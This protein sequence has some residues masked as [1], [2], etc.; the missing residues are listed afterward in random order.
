MSEKEFEKL[1]T[2]IIDELLSRGQKKD[3]NTLSF[4]PYE[5]TI[6]L[7]TEIQEIKNTNKINQKKKSTGLFKNNF[8]DI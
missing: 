2:K 6:N 3:I 4:P 7:P 8:I 1:K 5:N